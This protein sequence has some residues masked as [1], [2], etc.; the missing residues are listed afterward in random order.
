MSRE[1][2]LN[3]L[4]TLRVEAREAPAGLPS[5]ALR[6]AVPAVEGLGLLPFATRPT[7][8]AH[9][10]GQDQFRGSTGAT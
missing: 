3:P 1:S 6:P 7:V 10:I 5:R 8:T 2:T 9:S 4:V